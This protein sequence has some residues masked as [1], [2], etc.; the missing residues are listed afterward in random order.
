MNDD[1]ELDDLVSKIKKQRGAWKASRNPEVYLAD[2]L[3]DELAKEIDKEILE[4]LMRMDKTSKKTK[5]TKPK[6]KRK[7]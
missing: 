5:F 2:M 1:F 4:S 3:S 6:K 7:K